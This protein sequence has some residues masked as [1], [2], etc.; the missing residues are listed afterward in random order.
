MVTRSADSL[1]QFGVVNAFFVAR[2]MLVEVRFQ[3]S[4]SDGVRSYE[5]SILRVRRTSD[6]LRTN[7][8]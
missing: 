5:L 4:V 8:N 6:E 2:G 3:L 1:W 7:S